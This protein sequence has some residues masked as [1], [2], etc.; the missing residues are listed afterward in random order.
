[1]DSELAIVVELL[2]R[3]VQL[4]RALAIEL[5][6]GKSAMAALD[7]PTMERR[8]LEQESVVA[9]LAFVSAEIASMEALVRKRS[10]PGG[11][12]QKRLAIEQATTG[13]ARELTH[14]IRAHAALVRRSRRSID[15]LMNVLSTCTAEYSNSSDAYPV[16]R[17]F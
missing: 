12:D 4:L 15:V 17:Y 5:S 13:A 11:F 16:G 3:R 9:E 6:Q 14:A 10:E 1:M 2:E 7:L 8:T